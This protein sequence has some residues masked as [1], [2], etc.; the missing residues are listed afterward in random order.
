MVRSM[1]TDARNQIAVFLLEETSVPVPSLDYA[2]EVV[3]HAVR[4][5][6]VDHFIVV[7]FFEEVVEAV[8]EIDSRDALVGCDIV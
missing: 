3:Y 8:D 1:P 6:C 5:E 4:H 7:E 2:V